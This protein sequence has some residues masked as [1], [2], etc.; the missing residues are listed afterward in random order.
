MSKGRFILKTD[1]KNKKFKLFNMNRDGKGVYKEENRKPTLPFFFKL[2]WR[3]LSQLIRLNLMLMVQ[4]IPILVL[5][6]VYLAGYKT[7]TATE[8]LYAPLYGISKIAPVGGIT[9]LLDTQSI[10]MG[11]PIFTPVMLIVL[12]CLGVLLAITFGWF[13]AGS[14]YVLRGL[15]RGDPVF[16]WSDFFYA[17]KRNLKQ[18][19][20]MG[21]L[22]FACIAVLVSDFIFF[23]SRTG[24][25]Y[26]NDVMYLMIFAISIVYVIMRFYMYQLMITFDL[27]TMK[28]L[29]NSLIFTILG[30][31]RNVLAMIG[32]LLLIVLNAVFIVMFLSVGI[33]IPMVL[34]LFYIMAVM[35]FITTYAAYP[36][37]DKY[38]IAPYAKDNVP[39]PTEE[40]E[41]SEISDEE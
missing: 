25:S 29:K 37:I 6:Y 39:E 36:V 34:P 26:G 33:T 3:K 19:F 38:M 14:A 4:A 1:T 16:I 11:I 41:A 13:N 8:M 35:G 28:I 23:Y 31:K 40:T 32:L 18:A 15:F 22:D 20:F 17:I 24:S 5:V 21:L 2:L 12:I 7:A 27:S 9:A 10:Q 30:I